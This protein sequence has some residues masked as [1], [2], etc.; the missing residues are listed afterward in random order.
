MPLIR[1][2]KTAEQVWVWLE[3]NIS[4]FNC[5]TLY[6]HQHADIS[7]RIHT[8]SLNYQTSSLKGIFQSLAPVLLIKI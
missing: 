5:M 4:Y 1:N 6:V 3:T 2:R 8:E 7:E